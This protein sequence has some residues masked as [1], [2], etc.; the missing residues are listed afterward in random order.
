MTSPRDPNALARRAAKGA[1]VAGTL[2]VSALAL[3]T[4]VKRRLYPA[5]PAPPREAE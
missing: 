3:G 1:V 4:L 5:E 2:A